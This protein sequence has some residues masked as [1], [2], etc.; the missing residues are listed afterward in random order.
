[1]VVLATVLTTAGLAACSSPD[2]QLRE[3]QKNIQGLNA[4]TRAIA[5]AWLGGDVSPTYSR[6]AF[7]QT[8]QLLDKQRASLNAAP[9]LLLDPNGA[10]L[11]RD[12][13]QLSRALAALIDDA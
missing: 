8:L 4:T 5:E 10:S 7:E 11:S 6:T 2:N 9:R 13:E 1:A 12:A 3:A